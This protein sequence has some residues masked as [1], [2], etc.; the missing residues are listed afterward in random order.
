[1]SV[2]HLYRKAIFSTDVMAILYC[3]SPT[4]EP[5]KNFLKLEIET[6]PSEI[7][8]PCSISASTH[9]CLYIV[10][11][12][13]IL[14]FSLLLTS[15]GGKKGCK[16]KIWTWKCYL[17]GRYITVENLQ[18]LEAYT[19][20]Y[21]QWL[22]SVHEVPVTLTVLQPMSSPR[23]MVHSHNKLV[24]NLQ[25]AFDAFILLLCFHNLFCLVLPL[26]QIFLSV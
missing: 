11:T 9:P 3:V 24:A 20:K 16:I 23:Q 5:G 25:L 19:T 8:F 13:Y 7:W 18:P 4:I 17:E 21:F 1:M 22:C 12:A 2:K 6:S 15:F 10:M 26:S 14:D